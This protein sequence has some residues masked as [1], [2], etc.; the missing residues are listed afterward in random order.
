M[1][2]VT[3]LVSRFAVVSISVVE[4]RPGRWAFMID[5]KF[6]QGYY[7]PTWGLTTYNKPEEALKAGESHVQSA[8]DE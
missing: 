7:D 2:L 1:R 5:G 8:G 6:P 4:V 3:W